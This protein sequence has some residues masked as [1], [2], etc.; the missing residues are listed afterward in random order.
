[1]K[2]YIQL[3]ILSAVCL[4]CRTVLAE[5]DAWS[6]VAPMPT[7]RES[8]AACT[9][10]GKIYAI[11]GFPGGGDRGIDTNERYDPATNSWSAMAPMPTPRRMPVTGVVDGKCYVIGG[12]T[13]DRNSSLLDA[14]EA[15]D[16]A[17][18]SWSALTPM[19]TA[20]YAHAA[21]V[22]NGKIHVIGGTDGFIVLRSVEIYDPA[23]DTW[24]A[25]ASMATARGLHGAAVAGGKIYV[26]GGTTD[27]DTVAY[28]GMEIY[29]PVS[30]S[31]SAGPDMPLAK[32]SLSAATA[33]GRVYAIGGNDQGDGAL[34]NV[35]AFDLATGSWSNVAEM[36]EFR[37]RFASAVADNQ[38]YAIGGSTNFGNPHV[39]MDLVERYIPAAP[40]DTFN[41]NKGITDAWFNPATN[42]QG[43]YIIVFAESKQ[44]FVGW[45]TYDLERPPESA[46]T[47]L[48][49]PGHRWLTAQGPYSGDTANLTIYQTKGGVF[50]AQQPETETDPNGDGTMKIEFADCSAAL[51]TYE[52]TS[53]GISGEIP[54]QR[55]TDE[56][57]ELC[58]V[59]NTERN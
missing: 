33:N 16:P 12:R 56:N 27:G 40:T 53:L 31:W 45:F 59:L 8:V 38:I 35:V 51:L 43:F 19:P 34:K 25:G 26:M 39:G 46:A 9:V 48:G 6:P 24:S 32:F 57:I 20:R 13:S 23:T 2:R 1:M 10:D 17:T 58:D 28:D 36:N 15:Y 22:L 3:S 52:I 7:A 29:D 21:A 30:D 4:T 49:E 54:I 50:D 37:V 14:V 42:G 5:E 11:G 55:I 41:I 44:L 18:D 47:L